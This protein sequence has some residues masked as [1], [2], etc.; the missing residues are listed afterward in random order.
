MYFLFELS[1]NQLESISPTFYKC[2]CANILAP[3]KSLTFTASTK[4]LRTKLSYEKAL[5]KMLVKLTPYRGFFLSLSLGNNKSI[6]RL[7][8]CLLFW[9]Q[10][11]EL[12]YGVSFFHL[13][14]KVWSIMR[15]WLTWYRLWRTCKERTVNIPTA[16]TS[17]PTKGTCKVSPVD[18][19]HTPKWPVKRGLYT[20]DLEH[21]S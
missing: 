18:I 13:P 5:C 19:I 15:D 2:I 17:K 10:I 16:L 6:L 21:N 3:I 7:P 14:Y 8:K 4:K 20:W 12:K 11:T 9:V 1:L